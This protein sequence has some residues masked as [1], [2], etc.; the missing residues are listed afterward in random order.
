[1]LPARV[2]DVWTDTEYRA[3][4]ERHLSAEAQLAH[5]DWPR[6]VTRLRRARLEGAGRESP[7]TDHGDIAAHVESGGGHEDFDQLGRTFALAQQRLSGT[8]HQRAK[9]IIELV[10]VRKLAAV[11][12]ETSQAHSESADLDPVQWLQIGTLLNATRRLRGLTRTEL[13]TTLGTDAACISE[14]ENGLGYDD[15]FMYYPNHGSADTDIKQADLRE[16][17]GHA[18]SWLR[19]PATGPSLATEYQLQQHQDFVGARRS[20]PGKRQHVGASCCA[21]GQRADRRTRPEPNRVRA[22]H[23]SQPDQRLPIPER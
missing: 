3:H 21:L 20:A 9:S 7:N 23:R 19:R 10:A 17:T 4:L 16:V 2:P 8:A 18:V 22:V 12:A 1:M 15:G 5:S 13:A 14:I 11:N 6:L